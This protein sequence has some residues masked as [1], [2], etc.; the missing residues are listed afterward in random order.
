MP[1][2]HRALAGAD[3]TCRTAARPLVFG[4]SDPI[5]RT[6]YAQT[7]NGDDASKQ[8]LFLA[9]LLDSAL[10]RVTAR[11]IASTCLKYGFTRKPISTPRLHISL[12]GLGVYSEPLATEISRI[13]AT[14]RFPPL[15]ITLDNALSYRNRDPHPFVLTSEDGLETVRAFYQV[16]NARLSAE[17]FVSRK[18]SFN[19]HMT[20]LW[21][22]KLVPKHDLR[23]PLK[24]TARE[25]V[26]VRS[27]QGQ[28]R[29]DIIGRWPLVEAS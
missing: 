18:S 25:F 26:L 11:R 28:S 7:A 3:K 10:H 6:V 19:P 22:S 21:D 14:V 9:L 5:S 23:H 24:W 2:S 29:Y 27:Y 12:V 13:A 15:D 1:P 17:G 16:L 20:L 4:I 8:V